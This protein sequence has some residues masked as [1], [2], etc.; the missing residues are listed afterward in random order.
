MYRSPIFR[1]LQI[2]DGKKAMITRVYESCEWLQ[3]RGVKN[4]QEAGI[5]VG[6]APNGAPM[7][8]NFPCEDGDGGQNSPEAGAGTR[9][10]IP[11]PSFHLPYIYIYIYRK[12]GNPSPSFLTLVPLPASQLPS[13]PH[14]PRED[15]NPPFC[16]LSVLFAPSQPPPNTSLAASPLS[17]SAGPLTASSPHLAVPFFLRQRCCSVESV[18]LL[19]RRR[20]A[21]LHR[22]STLLFTCVC[23]LF[24]HFSLIPAF[25]FQLINN[26]DSF[27]ST[28]IE[29][30][31]EIEPTQDDEE[32]G[33]EVS[34]EVQN[35]PNKKGLT[36][37]AWKHF[38][39]ENIDGKWKEICK[40]CERKIGGDTKQGTKHLHDHIRICPIRTV[41]GPK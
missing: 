40:Y 36:S 29:N 28:P 16:V 2:L 12:F 22:I 8:G 6:T 34:Q 7:A 4:F 38:R 23:H 19:R 9:A 30:N 32:G 1:D 31:N 24:G 13:H 20:L 21:L 27:S 11:V 15:A 5:P 10:G 37:E 17:V 33:Q 3:H 41:R 25:K 14:P 18:Q 26:M 35:S 39:R